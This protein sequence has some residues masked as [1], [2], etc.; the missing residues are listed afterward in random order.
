MG[1][2]ALIGMA[3]LVASQ[4]FAQTA[5]T[6]PSFEVASV[7]VIP[8][9]KGGPDGFAPDGFPRTRAAPLEGFR[10]LPIWRGWYATRIISRGGVFCE[11]TRINRST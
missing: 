5:T 10:G 9:S 3:V 6:A 8:S 11:Q 1:I 4:S 2:P 7:R